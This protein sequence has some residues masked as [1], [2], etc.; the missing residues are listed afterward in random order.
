MPQ[1]FSRHCERSEAIQLRTTA[2]LDCFVALLLAMTAGGSF[3]DHCD[4][5]D[6]DP[7]GWLDE[8]GHLDHRHRRIDPAHH[9]FPDRADLR[10][11]GAILI[12]AD[13]IPGHPNDMLGPGAVLGEDGEGV[14]KHLAELAG[15]VPGGD[16]LVRVPADHAGGEYRPTARGDA[17]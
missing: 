3:R 14:E 16:P 7:G 13:D 10:E 9:L 17:V 11:A 15:K 2:P 5:L 12:E 8:R 4:R 1:P 6:L